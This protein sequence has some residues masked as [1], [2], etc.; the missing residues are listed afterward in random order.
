MLLA[1]SDLAHLSE[2]PQRWQAP[3]LRAPSLPLEVEEAVGEVEEVVVV[4]GWRHRRSQKQG[5]EPPSA[6]GLRDLVDSNATAVGFDYFGFPPQFAA[7][8]ARGDTGYSYPFE[9]KDAAV[10]AV[11]AA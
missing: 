10:L 5:L 3:L 9:G 11:G 1:R 6:S 7:K 8:R 2:Q 4:V